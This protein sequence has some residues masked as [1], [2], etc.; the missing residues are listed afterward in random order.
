MSKNLVIEKVPQSTLCRIKWE[1][2]G[3]L[4]EQLKGEFTNSAVAKVFIASWLS[5]NPDREVEVLV[6]DQEQKRGPGR[7]PGKKVDMS[8]L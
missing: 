8:S 5:Q 3:E 7:P 4:P 6:P 2:G 1:G